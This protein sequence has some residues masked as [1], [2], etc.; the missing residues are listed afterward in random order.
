MPTEHVAVR[1]H[2]DLVARIDAL[3]PLLSTKGHEARRSDAL[4]ALLVVAFEA[5]DAD[6][7]ILTARPAEPRAVPSA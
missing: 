5:V 6:P 4:R 1:P 7:G 3:T 2:P